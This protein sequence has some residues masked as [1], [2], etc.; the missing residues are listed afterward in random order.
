MPRPLC[1]NGN[2]RC[3]SVSMSTG[4]RCRRA[5]ERGKALCDTH[6]DRRRK[7]EKRAQVERRRAEYARKH[8]YFVTINLKGEYRRKP[9]PYMARRRVVGKPFDTAEEAWHWLSENAHQLTFER[10]GRGRFVSVSV[11]HFRIAT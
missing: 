5:A 3:C 1:E 10:P 11:D 4:Q 8:R 6:L 7:A 9:W 2:P